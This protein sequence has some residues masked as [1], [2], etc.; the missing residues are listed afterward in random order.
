MSRICETCHERV[1][2]CG[3]SDAAKIEAFRAIPGNE[4]AGPRAVERGTGIPYGTVH[5]ILNPTIDPG[6]SSVA[7]PEGY[8]PAPLVK[9]ERVLAA[10]AIWKQM[11]QLERQQ[12][13]NM[14]VKFMEGRPV[15]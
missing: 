2:D 13:I 10:W 15:I 12:L 6:G 7:E 8:E 9:T 1:C 14:V 11:D 3:L 5:R 4:K